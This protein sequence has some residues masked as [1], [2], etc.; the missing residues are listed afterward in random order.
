MFSGRGG[1]TFVQSLSPYM[2]FVQIVSV[3]WVTFLDKNR[4][5]FLLCPHPL[6]ANQGGQPNHNTQT[7][8]PKASRLG[9][10]ATASSSTKDQPA[11]TSDWTKSGK[12]QIL[13]VGRKRH[14]Q[15]DD[16]D[17][18]HISNDGLDGNNS[19]SDEEEGRTSAVKEKKRNIRPVVPAVPAVA[20]DVSTSTVVASDDV[21]TT[22]KKK[23]KGKKERSLDVTDARTT[24]TTNTA[25]DA[26]TYNDP[27]DSKNNKPQRKKIRS[28]QKNIRKDTRATEEKPTHLVHGNVGYAGRPLTKAT[29]DKL[30]L[31]SSE[32][33][34]KGGASRRN[35]SGGV[36]G[37]FDKGER[38]GSGENGNIVQGSY[39]STRDTGAKDDM[40]ENATKESKQSDVGEALS[41]IG[42]CIVDN[43]PHEKIYKP[44]DES[45]KDKKKRKAPKKKF[46]NLVVG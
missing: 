25:P 14:H 45:N 11:E 34:T 4:R 16:D 46:K 8:V 9:V 6:T 44:I 24:T 15:D 30:G 31:K 36:D 28:R 40:G 33:I 27:N 21:A 13:S 18:V 10:G 32:G 1:E 26:T 42:D 12:K 41:R 22:K 43:T 35:K 38:V 5:L 29:R 17:D 20:R 7:M 19:S 39:D 23:K 2:T 3:N 37:A